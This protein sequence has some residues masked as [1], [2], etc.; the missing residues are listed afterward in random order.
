MMQPVWQR[1]PEKEK[2]VIVGCDKNQEWLLSWWWERYSSE[3]SFPVCFVDF[4][5]TLD[6]RSW[7]AQ[8]GEVLSM[9][10]GFSSASSED[11]MS[12]DG[13]KDLYGSMFSTI[14]EQWFKKP[15]ACLASPFHR[16]AWID[17]DCEILRP[18]DGLFDQCDRVQPMA[19]MQEYEFNHLPKWDPSILYN[20]GVIVFLHGAEIFE[21]WAEAAIKESDRFLGDDQLLSSLI[22]QRQWPVGDLPEI[23]NWKC[24][25]GVNIN[26]VIYHWIFAVGKDFIKKQGGIKPHLEK[27]LNKSRI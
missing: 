5:M 6:A 9:E 14:R 15:F 1:A 16:S 26:A 12:N 7:C 22:N 24:V 2:G 8:R 17:L 27:F 19:L 21:K 10:I 3:N 13:I 25:W 18:I 23:Y 20:S 4:G 11:F